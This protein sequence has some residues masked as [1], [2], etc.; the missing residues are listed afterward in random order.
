[1]TSLKSPRIQ[2]VDA[3]RGFAIVAIL[4]LHN[5]EH[6]DY[7]F[8]PTGLPAWLVSLDKTIWDTMFF[9]FAG[10]AYGIFALL[11]GLT[12]YIQQHNQELKGKDFRARFAWRLVLLYGFGMINSSFYQGDILTI[13]AILGFTLIPVAKLNTKTVLF[14]AVILIL[15]PYEWIKVLSAIIHPQQAIPNPASWEYFGKMGEYIPKNSFID[16]IYG[17]LTNGKTAVYLWTWE[18][19]RVFQTPALFMFGMLLGRTQKFVKSPENNKFWTKALIYSLILFIPLY[20]VSKSVTSQ[21]ITN[22]AVFRS[23]ELITKSWTNFAFLVFLVS[24]FV[25]LYEN[26][27]LRNALDKFSV[28]G[29]MSMSNYV[30]QSILGSCIYY[31]FGLGLY[32]YTGATYSLLIGL[33]LMIIQW[34]FCKY[35]QKDHRYGVLEGV[36]HKLTWIGTSR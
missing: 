36:W 20:F 18:A 7:Y 25:L 14:I 16:T 35:W 10:K 27:N 24:G 9:L 17:N 5:L 12:F 33:M 13:Y 23:L 6:F 15:Q 30:M 1:M 19:G 29:R 22:T 31:G 2:S 4:L 26:T 8:L 21:S 32:Q 28:L 3:L 11:F 34:T